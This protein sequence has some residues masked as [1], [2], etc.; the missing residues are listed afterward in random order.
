M[1]KFIS[2]LV[3]LVAHCA[4]GQ[5]NGASFEA[6]QRAVQMRYCAWYSDGGDTRAH[7]FPARWS[8]G[9]GCPAYLGAAPGYLPYDGFYSAE[10]AQY[11]DELNTLVVDLVNL[12]NE[13]LPYFFTSAAEIQGT[14]S[15]I[16][17]NTGRFIPANIPGALSTQCPYPGPNASTH[18]YIAWLNE[19][20]PLMK[21]TFT[22]AKGSANLGG[23]R[24]GTGGF[25]LDPATVTELECGDGDPFAYADFSARGWSSAYG[26]LPFATVVHSFAPPTAS[27]TITTADTAL[28]ARKGACRVEFKNFLQPSIEFYAL[29]T[30]L[31]PTDSVPA[32]PPLPVDGVW[33]DAGGNV[34]SDPPSKTDTLA[35]TSKTFGTEAPK[36]PVSACGSWSWK[37]NYICAMISGFPDAYFDT[38]SGCE[39]NFCSE[40]DAV[41]GLDEVGNGAASGGVGG[42]GGGLGGAS[43]WGQ[44]GVHWRMGL[45]RDR[46]GMS[47]ST[48]T[49]DATTPTAVT[50][51][52]GR[53]RLNLDYTATVVRGANNLPLQ[54]LTS[55]SVVNFVT[56]SGN[57]LELDQYSRS[58]QGA[59]QANGTYAMSGSPYRVVVIQNGTQSDGVT[60][61]IN[62][63][64]ID[65]TDAG[66][67]ER[68]SYYF[69]P[70]ATFADAGIWQMTTG[71]GIRRDVLAISWDP[72]RTIRTENRWVY[73]GNNHLVSVHQSVFQS[74]AWGVEKIADI[75]DPQGDNL[76]PHGVALSTV[77]A[78]Y[79]DSSQ[80]G[81]YGHVYSTLQQPSGHW[82]TYDYDAYGRRI[83]RVTQVGDSAFASA[84]NLNNVTAVI[85]G[86]TTPDL[87]RVET[88]LGA[89]IARR[90]ESYSTFSTTRIECTVAGA[91]WNDPTNLVTV[92]K[93]C[94]TGTFAVGR[95]QSALN[96]DGTATIYS[97]SR[98]SIAKT[99]T[100]V[101]STGAAN[102]QTTAIVDGT[103]TTKVKNESG[104]VIFAETDDIASGLL[105]VSNTTTAFD[106]Y[107]RPVSSLYDDGST[108][109]IEE[110]CCG[111]T[112]YTDRT[113]SV[114]MIGY[115][116]L[117]RENSENHANMTTLSKLDPEGRLL[118][119]DRQGSDDSLIVISTAQYDMAGR[120][121]QATQPPSNNGTVRLVTGIS[122]SYDGSGHRIVVTINPD[123]GIRMET[124]FQDGTLNSL[125][126]T[127]VAPYRYVY[128]TETL[129]RNGTTINCRTT[130]KICLDVNGNDTGE[131]TK[132]YTDMMSRVVR[133]VTPREV[134]VGGTAATDS[135]YNSLGQ[136]ASTVDPDGLMTLY[137]YNSRGELT[138]Q[139]IDMDRNGQIDLGGTDLITSTVQT[140][141]AGPGGT[142]VERITIQQ[143]QTKNSGTPTTVLVDDM[144]PSGRQH[145]RTK[146]GL[147]TVMTQSWPGGGEVD[148]LTTYPDNSTSSQVSQDGLRL[149]Q[150]RSAADGAII[151][152]R[153]F[154]YDS[155]NRLQTVTDVR[156]GTTTYANNS[157]DTVGS[158]TTP[159]PDAVHPAQTTRYH[160]GANGKKDTETEPDGA[161]VNYLYTFMGALSNQYGGR[162]YPVSYGYDAQGRMTTLTTWQNYPGTPA[163]T[164]WVYDSSS[165]RL[166]QKLYADQKGPQYTYS[167]AGRV[168]TLTWARGVT[169]SYAYD[170]AGMTS[171]TSYSDGTQAVTITRDRVG[172]SQTVTDAAGTRIISYTAD[173]QIKDDALDPGGIFAG[174]HVVRGYDSLLRRNLVSLENGNVN[175]VSTG[176]A[177]DGVSRLALVTSGANSAAY[178]YE[179]DDGALVNTIAYAVN[180][181]GVLTTT[182][183][184]DHLNRL[185]S[186]G[187]T[188][189]GQS[190]PMNAVAYDYD[191]ANQRKTQTS[192]DG[193]YWSY[194]Y[195]GLG[196][197]Q[198]GQKSLADGTAITGAQYGY[199]FDTIGNRTSTTVNNRTASYSAN[200]LNQYVSRDVPGMVD[201]LGSTSTNT[202]ISVNGQSAV[203]QGPLFYD[204]VSISNS[205][206]ASAS[207]VQVVGVKNNAGP[208]GEDVIERETRN[209]FLPQTPE[210]FSYDE[211]GNLTQDGHWNYTWNGENELIEIETR[212]DLASSVPRLRLT[213]TYD[214]KHRRIQ[215]NVF[216]ADQGGNFAATATKSLLFLYDGWN[217]VGELDV[218]NSNALLR[219]YAWGL[220]LSGTMAGAGGAGGLLFEN[221]KISNWACLADG[222]GNVA[223]LF[224]LF[225]NGNNC[226][227]E[228]G[229]FGEPLRAT[230]TMAGFNPFRWSTKFTDEESALVYYGYR[231]YEPMRA[232]WLSRD[233]IWEFGG[234]NIYGFL[235]NASINSVDVCGLYR[236]SVVFM[237]AHNT[238]MFDWLRD[239]RKNSDACSRGSG[240]ACSIDGKN[241]YQRN[242]STSQPPS[243][244][245]S[246]LYGYWNWQEDRIGIGFPTW[247]PPRP[248]NDGFNNFGYPVP[249]LL[250]PGYG[251]IWVYRDPTRDEVKAHELQLELSE[252]IGY[253]TLLKGNWWATL[254]EADAMAE[255]CK[256]QCKEITARFETGKH[257]LEGFLTVGQI[258]GRAR[259]LLA[260][261][262]RND[263]VGNYPPGSFSNLAPNQMPVPE[264]PTPGTMVRFKCRNS[265]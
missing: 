72:T 34:G 201:V 156:N 213:F 228:Y 207:Q 67:T 202:T 151:Q 92:K 121:T 192:A 15:G 19:I 114:T 86:H 63:I 206:Q 250:K 77:Y 73:D 147:T 245:R 35:Y 158:L 43:G 105:L 205:S 229:P 260:I 190:S 159:V 107:G 97:Y 113:G 62:S 87:T 1:K 249:P 217:L 256:C 222:N 185:T 37:F 211:D 134:A 174:M 184:Y 225:G 193:S 66:R 50:C 130:Q 186:V 85:Y 230:G 6:L 148:S 136:L 69:W 41:G 220:D 188:P 233:P 25:G 167:A 141:A 172:G 196:Q 22:N 212:S 120:L 248:Q 108:E 189:A 187:H 262:S 59:K 261:Y 200:L 138:M 126:G 81:R 258:L 68:T 117:N 168:Q 143:W 144:T 24:F 46:Y 100:T 96:L 49:L 20:V 118:E 199:T 238:E 231:Y 170:N 28:F 75:V 181:Q 16:D 145:W 78:Y 21:V 246:I 234:S 119:T 219:T 155:H 264:V 162:E 110:G 90:Y 254:R 91:A 195:D 214:Y 36:A 235:G 64:T 14:T 179:P 257:R 133:T 57:C 210:S 5:T 255:N 111:P 56:L 104:A 94:S 116:D 124:Y 166:T 11:P 3:L 252:A 232:K 54:V 226:V 142:P 251:G 132:T 29:L 60:P 18:E 209:V 137:A 198:S 223:A 164:K 93:D 58:A 70:D 127:A 237:H 240:L 177:Y 71:N 178:G 239:F 53:I 244:D 139:A 224:D 122:E 131:W 247:P 80:P 51:T 112:K 194:G 161:V 180:A 227:Y 40:S 95:P 135:F 129:S 83:K 2:I 23:D 208:N 165:G 47:G 171:G 215:K 243:D 10:F 12:C 65:V 163:V 242:E 197:V 221:S 253:I 140:V 26:Y 160:Y 146:Y 236:C 82:I 175:L 216:V 265:E 76:D 115:D 38:C 33:H 45:G 89:E 102:A 157:D 149:S 109:S 9:T 125:T 98:D 32:N 74:F 150:S 263:A 52:S 31:L 84:D 154:G 8:D 4:F 152:K 88:Y 106:V 241:A 27:V 79:T 259:D 182:K 203:R 44:P 61:D 183:Q 169:T 191:S 153:T 13:M 101:T 173:G 204:G 7:I 176:Y 39:G 103:R 218:L 128:G 30:T 42:G 48:L 17:A 55:G 123:G 99:E